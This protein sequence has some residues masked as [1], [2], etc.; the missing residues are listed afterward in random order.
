MPIPSDQIIGYVLKEAMIDAEKEKQ[1]LHQ[2]KEKLEQELTRSQA[3]LSNIN[4]LNKATPEKIQ[5]E[6]E[7]QASY[8]AQYDAIM[9]QLL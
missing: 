4:F 1:L 8:Q 6:K 3:L 5:I 7:K 2:Q 9:K